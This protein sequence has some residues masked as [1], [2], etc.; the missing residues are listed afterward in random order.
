[1][2]VLR[3]EVVRLLDVDD[4]V[5]CVIDPLVQETQRVVNTL[6]RG[7]LLV[8]FLLVTHRLRHVCVILHVFLHLL[9]RL[10]HSLPREN[11]L[12]RQHADYVVKIHGVREAQFQVAV[13]Q[14]SQLLFLV[15]HRGLLVLFFNV[16]QLIELPFQVDLRLSVVLRDDLVV[17]QLG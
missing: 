12:L 5:R 4:V 15:F 17:L 3:V 6:D 7:P 2:V 11:H 9:L 16:D 10:L 14:R 13:R 8:E 1:M